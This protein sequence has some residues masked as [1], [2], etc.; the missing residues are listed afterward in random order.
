ME[1]GAAY[2]VYT[3]GV[4]GAPGVI[5]LDLL[6]GARY[7]RQDV[8]IAATLGALG[9]PVAAAARSGQVDWVDPI[10]GARL[11]YGVAPGQSVLL[12][13]DI[14][15]FG[16]GSE[17]SWQVLATYNAKICDLNGYAIDGFVGYRALA[18]DYSQGSGGRRYE[19]DAVQHGPVLGMSVRF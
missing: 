15:G 5:N 10:V 11:G 1:F 13:G 2:T 16:V 19:M 6:A 18:V 17:F 7:W 12:R 3:D 9:I 8:E 4:V 14:G